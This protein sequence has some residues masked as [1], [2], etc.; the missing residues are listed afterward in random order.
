MRTNKIRVGLVG[1]GG[2]ARHAHVPALLSNP[3]VELVALCDP[4]DE[5]IQRILASRL[6]CRVYHGLDQL[7]EH[8]DIDVVD[9]CT[10]SSLHYAQAR[11]A[12]EAG[13]NVLVEKPP[14]QTVEQ[15]EELVVLANQRDLKLGAVFNYRYRDLIIALK[16]AYDQDLL[17]Q[18]VKIHVVHHGPMI[19]GD[20]PWLWD[21]KQSKYLLWEFGI[22][23]LDIMVHLCGP[24]ETILHVLP[25]RQES[26]DST[27]DLEVTVRFRN[28]T[29]G[30]LEIT[31]DT[32]RH[33]SFFTHINVYGTAM[34]AFIRFSPPSIRIVAGV[35]NPLSILVDDIKGVL[36]VAAKVFTGRY[37]AYRNI[38][39][40]RLIDGYIS[41]VARDSNFPL[42]LERAMPTLRL[43]ADIEK[44]IPSYQ[45]QDFRA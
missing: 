12:L 28:G 22:H 32:T 6:R 14:T 45:V 20:V 43:L 27:T 8:E 21:E 26:I 39:H 9:I 15:A 42:A 23:F 38:S 24:H 3:Q 13:V 44:W 19:Y 30:K 1:C 2:N 16:K 37:A 5:A 4:S 29:L 33:S 40:K 25:I 36:G 41:W 10:P 7:L 18:I 34:D 11:Q 31:S 17:G 35:H